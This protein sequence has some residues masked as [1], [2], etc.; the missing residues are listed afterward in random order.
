MLPGSTIVRACPTCAVPVLQHTL[1]SGNT[2]GAR[3]W[4]DGWREAPMLPDQPWLVK[5]P[6][7]SALFWID[8]AQQLAE[9]EPGLRPSQDERR[10]EDAGDVEPPC[11]EDYHDFIPHVHGDQ[12]KERYVRT[13]AWWASNT[14]RREHPSSASPITEAE[15]GNLESLL[16]LIGD[17]EPGDVIMKAEITR[18]LGR[19]DECQRLLQGEFEDRYGPAVELIR[20]LAGERQACVAE[21]TF[22]EKDDAGDGSKPR[23]R[24]SRPSQKK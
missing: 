24:R 5:C 11:A 12:E 4:T 23:H 9:I 3:F 7:C 1:M 19:F 17:E 22:G 15:R 13:R 21:I 2:F 18:E 8:E 10:Y 6:K 16:G 14:K 20:R